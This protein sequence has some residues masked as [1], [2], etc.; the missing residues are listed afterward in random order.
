M[1]TMQYVTNNMWGISVVI[2][3]ASLVYA[4]YRFLNG[5]RKSLTLK[6]ERHSGISRI[7]SSDSCCRTNR[8]IIWRTSGRG[9][10]GISF[11]ATSNAH[12]IISARPTQNAL[13]IA[14]VIQ[15]SSI[16]IIRGSS[17]SETWYVMKIAADNWSTRLVIFRNLTKK[18]SWWS[19][20]S[21]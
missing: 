2:M 19:S 12:I 21:C 3:P 8:L 9:G 20:Q 13:R 11:T 4:A 10:S 18:T 7:L 14:I 1:C 17:S 16:S 6:V 15:I 5:L